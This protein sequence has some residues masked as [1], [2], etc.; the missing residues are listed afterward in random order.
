MAESVD[1]DAAPSSEASG[2]LP[3]P[4]PASIATTRKVRRADWRQPPEMAP[5]VATEL[6]KRLLQ[7]ETTIGVVGSVHL[8]KVGPE[9]NRTLARTVYRWIFDAHDVV[10]GDMNCKWQYMIEQDA[11][12]DASTHAHA[13]RPSYLPGLEQHSLDRYTGK[14]RPIEP[15]GFDI[16]VV[17]R[18]LAVELLPKQPGAKFTACKLPRSLMKSLQWPSDH[19]SVVATVRG[20]GSTSL[21]FAT[22]NVAE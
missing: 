5:A 2:E 14:P 9:R 22:W 6:W 4:R 8:E 1:T 19:T 16:I 20:K 13:T 11:A 15:P 12:V 10:M 7:A 17:T 21:T 3:A 18:P